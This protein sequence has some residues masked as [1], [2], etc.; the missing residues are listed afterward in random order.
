MTENQLWLSVS[1]VQSII[2]MV[3]AWHHAGTHGAGE[4]AESSTCSS[5]GKQKYR[6]S[7]VL[8]IVS[9]FETSMP[10]AIPHNS[11]TPSGTISQTH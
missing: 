4:R 10:K 11:V 8:G 1:E 3:R 7:L 2:L 9:N 5:T 6:L